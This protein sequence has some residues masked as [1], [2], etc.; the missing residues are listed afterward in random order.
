L[1][2]SIGVAGAAAITA[3]PPNPAAMPC[4]RTT[5]EMPKVCESAGRIFGTFARPA[6]SDNPHQPNFSKSKKPVLQLIAS[7][8]QSRK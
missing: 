8:V 7:T 4:L 1:Y 5:A 2:V 3:R 6:I